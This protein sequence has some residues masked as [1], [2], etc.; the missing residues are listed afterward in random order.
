MIKY[1]NKM[2]ELEDKSLEEC[3]SKINQIMDFINKMSQY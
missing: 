2:K 1:G 3:A